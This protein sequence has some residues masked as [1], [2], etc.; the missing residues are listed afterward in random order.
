MRGGR[1]AT[2]LNETA[3]LPGYLKNNRIALVNK[4]SRFFFG[5]NVDE[6][7]KQDLSI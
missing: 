6:I 2:D 4:V 1:K 7:T 3:E 5:L